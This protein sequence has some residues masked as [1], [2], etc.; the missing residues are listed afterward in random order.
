MKEHTVAVTVVLRIKKSYDVELQEVL[1]EMDYEFDHPMI[2]DMEI[3]NI[4]IL[5]RV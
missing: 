1:N 4:E 3:T 5:E 2:Q